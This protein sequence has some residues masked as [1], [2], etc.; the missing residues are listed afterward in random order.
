MQ[1]ADG[2]QHR[3][4]FDC[5]EPEC[6]AQE[7]HDSMHSSSMHAHLSPTTPLPV[8]G[9]GLF[10]Q[11]LPPLQKFS[12]GP[13]TSDGETFQ[14]W[15]DQFELVAGVC[16]WD[17]QAK[18]VNLVTRLHR[19]AYLFYRSCTPQQCSSYDVFVEELSKS[20]TSVQM[21]A[22]IS[23][24]FLY[25]KQKQGETGD[26]FVQKFVSIIHSSLSTS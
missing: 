13:T 26:S 24:L 19:Q 4:M 25:W 21:Q 17:S 2:Y 18:L 11:Q 23:S 20:F 14:D 12:G 5:G 7:E 22:I 3:V 1:P 6:K 15:K 9:S 10:A 8:V 16:N